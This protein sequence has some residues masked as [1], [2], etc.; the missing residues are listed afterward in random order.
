[1]YNNPFINPYAAQPYM[2]TGMQQQAQQ[3]QRLSW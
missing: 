3:K 1:M 2:Q